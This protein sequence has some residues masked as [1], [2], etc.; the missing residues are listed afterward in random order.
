MLRA[1]DA[2]PQRALVV[3]GAGRIAGPREQLPRELEQVVGDA[4]LLRV[5][6]ELGGQDAGVGVPCLA[7]AGSAG[8]VGASAGDL[9]PEV[10][11]DAAVAQLAGQLVA[12]SST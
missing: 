7:V 12:A 4:A 11:G 10:L 3:V 1:E 5:P 9:A 8:G 6:T 2:V